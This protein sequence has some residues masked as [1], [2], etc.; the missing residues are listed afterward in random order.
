MSQSPPSSSKSPA[1][2]ASSTN[3]NVILE[4]ALKAYKAK[5]KRDLTT[6]PLA[7]QFGACN[8]PTAI[9]SILQDQV[10]QFEQSRNA[11]ERLR[12]WLNPTINVLYAFSVILSQGVSLVF[13]PSQVIFAGAGVLL[14]AA[15][16]V[17]A[18]QD[19]LIDIF[20]R[21]ENIFR[22]LEIYT[23]VT[24]TPAMTDMMV[25]IMIE[26]LDIL[27]TATKEMNQSRFK[28]FLK[29]VAGST[30][31]EDGLQ[32]LDKMTNEEVKMANAE[33]LR[34]SQNID[35][36]VKGV[37]KK[38]QGVGNQV[39]DVDKNVQAVNKD[40]QVVSEQ[41]QGVDENVKVI[42]EKVQVVIDGVQ[43][44]FQIVTETFTNIN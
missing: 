9:L 14:L 8:S 29:K 26:V 22:R 31:L 25:K 28:K 3:F 1:T 42:E 32:K 33:I 6:H 7:S 35:E 39:K 38:V 4:K 43:A 37:D 5:T 17:E 20:E 15:K 12:R 24:P 36:N 16:D 10:H 40:V 41:V 27:A 21:I 19:L 30:K 18:S 11:D 44:R 13:S 34:L 23:D 2:T